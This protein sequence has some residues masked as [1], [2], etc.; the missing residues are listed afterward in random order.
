[1][2]DDT[3]DTGGHG[4]APSLDMTGR[5]AGCGRDAATVREAGSFPILAAYA[6]DP[7][8]MPA[9]RDYAGWLCNDCGT[10]GQDVAWLR[11]LAA[12]PAPLTVVSL[13]GQP[14][15]EPVGPRDV[16]GADAG[17]GEHAR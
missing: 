15:E 17:A 1:V 8:T 10:T 3:K 5:C 14:N 13:P 11:A 6:G 2:N 9:G 12:R 4:M 7:A 16:V